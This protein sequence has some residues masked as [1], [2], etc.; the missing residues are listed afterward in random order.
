MTDS[1]TNSIPTAAVPRRTP[2][3]V[4]SAL[5]V[6]D[7][8]EGLVGRKIQAR[9]G[10]PVAI[11]PDSPVAIA[12]YGRDDGVT[13]A[14][15]IYDLAL[16]NAI[17]AAL[18]SIPLNVAEVNIKEKKITDVILDNFKEVLNIATQ[19]FQRPGAP[20]VSCKSMHIAPPDRVPSSAVPAI[21]K[22]VGRA[23]LVIEIPGYGTGKITILVR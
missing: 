11:S 2:C 20:R 1:N 13:G 5:A 17:G 7:L 16:A 19:L 12:L 22:P 10:T 8:I 6:K 23:D 9:V 18:T 21:T 3:V 14:V 15:C 4:P